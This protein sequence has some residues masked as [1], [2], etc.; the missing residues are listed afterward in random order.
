MTWVT[1]V[2]RVRLCDLDGLDFGELIGLSVIWPDKDEFCEV[3][4]GKQTNLDNQRDLDDQDDLVRL[5]DLAGLD[6]G[7]WV[8]WVTYA[9]DPYIWVKWD[10]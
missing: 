7:D 3:Q 10:F 6:L 2:V 8:T 1:K 5:G 9:G 4:L